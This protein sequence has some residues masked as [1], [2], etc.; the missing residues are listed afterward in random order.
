MKDK[1]GATRW[2]YVAV[3]IRGRLPLSRGRP[4]TVHATRSRQ[5][6][7]VWRR[8]MSA[9]TGTTAVRRRGVLGRDVLARAPGP[10]LASPRPS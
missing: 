4:R 8:R 2:G 1:A 9:L 3:E 5:R 7:R 6:P 10:A